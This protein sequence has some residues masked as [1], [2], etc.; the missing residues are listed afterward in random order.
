M[1]SIPIGIKHK[2][3]KNMFIQAQAVL[4]GDEKYVFS[5]LEQAVTGLHHI[6]YFQRKMLFDVSSVEPTP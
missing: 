3:A 2:T 5:V 1:I 4:A 6:M